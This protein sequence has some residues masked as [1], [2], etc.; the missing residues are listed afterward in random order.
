[1]VIDVSMIS[2]APQ[3]G[4]EGHLFICKPS[5]GAGLCIWLSTK[6]SGNYEK[7]FVFSN[8]AL[9]Q[10]FVEWSEWV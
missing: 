9:I 5:G 4:A 7:T 3:E 6:I 10:T 2:I 8:G 1:M